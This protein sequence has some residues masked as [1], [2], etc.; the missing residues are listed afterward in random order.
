MPLSVGRCPTCA[1]H[2]P[3]HLLYPEHIHI[4]CVRVCHGC[5]LDKSG[6]GG[7]CCVCVCV[8]IC[9]CSVLNVSLLCHVIETLLLLSVTP[10][11]AG[12]AG[13]YPSDDK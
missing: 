1:K 3:L 4:L 2:V 8:C 9:G 13:K 5:S 6:S 7:M 10:D 12:E 11:D